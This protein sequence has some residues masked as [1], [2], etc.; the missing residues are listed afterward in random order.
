MSKLE[1]VSVSTVLAVVLLLFPFL[2]AV[3]NFDTRFQATGVV[4]FFNPAMVLAVVGGSAYYHAKEEFTDH[5][6]L[7]ISSLGFPSILFTLISTSRIA[8]G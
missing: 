1:K 6:R 7:I 3:E 2:E 5:V 8:F 4:V